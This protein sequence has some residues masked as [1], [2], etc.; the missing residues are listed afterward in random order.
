MVVVATAGREH[1]GQRDRA[2][3]REVTGRFG[4]TAQEHGCRFSKDEKS[5]AYGRKMTAV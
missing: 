3:H 2:Q 1:A 5:T 4:G